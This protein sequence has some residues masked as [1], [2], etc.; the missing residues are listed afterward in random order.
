MTLRQPALRVAVAT[1]LAS[2]IP[3]SHR[4]QRTPSHSRLGNP[5]KRMSGNIDGA[6]R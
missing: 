5:F 6:A 3:S 1:A 4:R 2:D